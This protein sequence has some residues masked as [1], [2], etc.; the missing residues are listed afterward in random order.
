MA[1]LSK[2]PVTGH[3]NSLV[4]LIFFLW[5][6][7]KLV[8]FQKHLLSL[9]LYFFKMLEKSR[10]NIVEGSHCTIDWRGL[11]SRLH[12]L[13]W[14]IGYIFDCYGLGHVTLLINI[15]ENLIRRRTWNIYKKAWVLFWFKCSHSFDNKSG[16]D[17]IA[18][19]H[20]SF[21]TLLKSYIQS[22]KILPM[23]SFGSFLI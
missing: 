7:L 20:F 13:F 6:F 22:Y 21:L 11:F 4:L 5:Y 1:M 8:I 16:F 15:F 2:K 14:P 9:S 17:K 10:E 23:N 12:V 3:Y 19:V 18:I